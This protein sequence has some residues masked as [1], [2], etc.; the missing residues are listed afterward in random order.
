VRENRQ[1]TDN[2]KQGNSGM[3]TQHETIVHI[4]AFA[5]FSLVGFF[6]VQNL[7]SLFVSFS[8]PTLSEGISRR[9]GLHALS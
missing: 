1:W 7:F 2:P 8:L 9:G 3:S 4:Q 6:F 5:D